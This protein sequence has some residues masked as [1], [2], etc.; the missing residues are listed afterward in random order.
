MDTLL[1]RT[2]VIDLVDDPMADGRAHSLSIKVWTP[3]GT[4]VAE[5]TQTA[6]TLALGFLERAVVA[7]RKEV[8]PLADQTYWRPAYAEANVMDAPKRRPAAPETAGEASG[9]RD[10][11]AETAHAKSSR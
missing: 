11:A 4:P 5:I 10:Q 8:Q 2:V 9:R 1:G 6:Q 7:M 3:P